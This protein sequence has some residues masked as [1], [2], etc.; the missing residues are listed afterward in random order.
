MCSNQIEAVRDGRSIIIQSVDNGNAVT[1]TGTNVIIGSSNLPTG[2]SVGNSG[3]MNNGQTAGVTTSGITNKDFIG[4]ID[5]FEVSYTGTTN[6]IDMSVTVGEHTYLAQNINSNPA[7]DT[8]VRFSSSEGG[9]F[10]IQMAANKGEDIDSAGD[11]DLATLQQRLNAAFDSLEF[12]QT[13]EIS[14]YQ[15]SGSILTDGVVTGTLIGTSFELRGSDFSDISID[16]IRVNAPQGSSENGSLIITVNG[17]EYRTASNIGDQLGANTPVQ[18][19]NALDAEKVLT[20]NT[21]DISIEFD[22][23]AKAAALEDALRE[24]FGVGDGSAELQFQVGVTVSDTLKVGINNVDTRTLYGGLTLDV[25]TA[26]NAAIASDR[27]DLAIDIVTSVRAEVGALQ[28]RFDFAAANVESSLQNQDA[29]RGVLLDTDVAA[30]STS[31]ATSQVKL[32]AGIAV[33]AQANLLPQNL[34]KLIG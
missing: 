24:A 22:T 1:K 19:V 5:G 27:I 8:T 11:A 17:E 26:E 31:F 20:F 15:G 6:L 18:L 30:E 7:T 13:R 34:L 3:I 9:Y 32:Q 2:T 4:K 33:L 12:T 23:D 28:S 14:S 16:S 10:D 25:T 21:G 29:A